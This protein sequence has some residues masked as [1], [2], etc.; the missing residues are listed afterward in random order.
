MKY[1]TGSVS[2]YEASVTCV[3]AV[4]ELFYP[5]SQHNK[6]FPHNLQ[7]IGHSG[8]LIPA[9]TCPAAETAWDIS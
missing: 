1:R 4:S 8:L 7:L 3:R 9:T 6:N 5:V 2:L